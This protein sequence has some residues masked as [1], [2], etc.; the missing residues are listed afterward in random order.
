ME[1]AAGQARTEAAGVQPVLVAAGQDFKGVGG[2][3]LVLDE[4]MRELWG[5]K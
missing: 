1:T 4:G 5:Q 3:V 2:G